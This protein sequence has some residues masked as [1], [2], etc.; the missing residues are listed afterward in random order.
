MIDSFFITVLNYIQK[1]NKLQAPDA[2]ADDDYKAEANFKMK[3]KQT[4]KPIKIK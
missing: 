1:E 2:L 4:A 3:C